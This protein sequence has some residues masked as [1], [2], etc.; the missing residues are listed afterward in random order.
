MRAGLPCPPAAPHPP[1]PH[2]HTP[3]PAP[4]QAWFC[5]SP[6]TQRL[7][8]APANATRPAFSEPA[9]KWNAFSLN[10]PLWASQPRGRAAFP[11]LSAP[12]T[13]Q[14]GKGATRHRCPRRVR[15]REGRRTSVGERV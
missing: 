1:A 14:A 5:F 12:L 3:P 2:T 11:H 6:I 9:S 13:R 4:A 15:S 7:I 8:T 10:Q